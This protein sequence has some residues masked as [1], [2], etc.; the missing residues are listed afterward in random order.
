MCEVCSENV[1]LRLPSH[2]F[3]FL[4]CCFNL[5]LLRRQCSQRTNLVLRVGALSRTVCLVAVFFSNF[6]CVATRSGRR[7]LLCLQR[8][9]PIATSFKSL[10]CDVRSYPVAVGW[11][12]GP[13]T[14]CDNAVNGMK[15][16]GAMALAKVLPRCNKLTTLS[17]Q[18]VSPWYLFV[19][20]CA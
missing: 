19:D 7:V 6:I 16:A 11:S 18:G 12:G 5:C 1:T 15:R 9:F 14:C 20:F 2:C 8:L 10:I 17:L 4:F 3:L 13:H